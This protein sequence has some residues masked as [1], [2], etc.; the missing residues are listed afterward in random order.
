M[1]I[2]FLGDKKVAA[3]CIYFP[4]CSG[5]AQLMLQALVVRSWNFEKSSL[6]C[7][8]DVYFLSK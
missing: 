8:S 4:L 1:L 7:S 5:N 6:V 2:F 3:S